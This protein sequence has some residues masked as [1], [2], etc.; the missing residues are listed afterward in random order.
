MHPRHERYDLAYAEQA[1]GRVFSA[2]WRLSGNPF[3][4]IISSMRFGSIPVLSDGD[5][6]CG[7]YTCSTIVQNSSD[8]SS[9]DIRSFA[10]RIAINLCIIMTTNRRAEMTETYPPVPL[11]PI[12]SKC[13]QGSFPSF[14]SSSSLSQFNLCIISLIISNWENPLTPPPS[15]VRTCQQF[16]L[17]SSRI[18]YQN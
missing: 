9:T 5:R 11:P 7:L 10:N 18:S 1:P 16:I 13:S 6:P 4:F 8:A 14:D 3:F 2:S 15:I 12:K 17:A